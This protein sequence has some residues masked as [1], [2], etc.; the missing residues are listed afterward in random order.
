ML[1]GGNGVPFDWIALKGFAAP[2]ALSGGLTPDNV[3]EAIK[4]TGAVLV[5]VSSG[6]ERAP[7]EKDETLVRRFIR[8]VKS[9]APQTRAKAS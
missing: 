3:G 9:A 4:L 8:T 7:G 1:P 5:D 6:V 2:F